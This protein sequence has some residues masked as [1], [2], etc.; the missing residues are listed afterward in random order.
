MGMFRLHKRKFLLRFLSRVQIDAIALGTRRIGHGYALAKYPTLMHLVKER[1][2]AIEVNPVSN[3]VKTIVRICLF[4]RFY[5]KWFF[6]SQ[7]GANACARSAQ[8]SGGHVLRPKYANDH[9]IR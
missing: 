2:I 8:S 4:F 7:T 3:Q 9:L 1:D 5:E 6:L